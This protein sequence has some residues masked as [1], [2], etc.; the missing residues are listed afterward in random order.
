MRLRPPVVRRI[1]DMAEAGRTAADI[2]RTLN[3]EGIA[4]SKGKPWST[5]SVRSILTNEVYTGTLLWG[6]SAKSRIDPVRVEEAFPATVSKA[7]FFRVR[8]QMSSSAP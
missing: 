1:F 8:E 2:A 6:V 3:E 7:Q 4:N 5:T